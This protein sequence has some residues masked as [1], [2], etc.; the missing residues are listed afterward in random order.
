MNHHLFTKAKK[1]YGENRHT[2]RAGQ[3]LTRLGYLLR[4]ALS[5]PSRAGRSKNHFDTRCGRYRSSQHSW[6]LS[7]PTCPIAEPGITKYLC[8]FSC[9]EVGQLRA[10]VLV[11]D[12]LSIFH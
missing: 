6:P 1:L 5:D 10:T 9:L 12:S 2:S 8:I 4:Y 11:S 3:M 7:L